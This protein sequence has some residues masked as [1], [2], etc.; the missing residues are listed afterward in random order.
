MVD[1]NTSFVGSGGLYYDPDLKLFILVD[2]AGVCLF[3]SPTGVQL[4]IFFG[5]RFFCSS[6]I[7]RSWHP[8]I[9]YHRYNQKYVPRRKFIDKG[10]T[11]VAPDTKIPD[12][13]CGF[14]SGLASANGLTLFMYLTMPIMPTIDSE[15]KSTCFE[16]IRVALLLSIGIR[17]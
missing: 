6:D 8:G 9:S 5:S 4:L 1:N 16:E 2:W 10:A 15:Q 11:K 13:M 7:A 3:S 17:F 14:S 12:I